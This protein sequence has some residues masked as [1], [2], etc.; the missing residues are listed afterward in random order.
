MHEEG[1]NMQSTIKVVKQL[2]NSFL[3]TIQVTILDYYLHKLSD[4]TYG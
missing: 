1:H 4:L 2:G 3:A